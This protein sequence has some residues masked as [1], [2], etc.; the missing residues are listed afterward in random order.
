[1]NLE[2]ICESRCF[3]GLK[4]SDMPTKVGVISSFSI[5]FK[6]NNSRYNRY[7]NSYEINR[8]TKIIVLDS[9]FNIRKSNILQFR[10]NE[11]VFQIALDT[12]INDIK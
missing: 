4:F 6:K 5:F 7:G 8:R 3:V 1:M 12:Y 2:F 9:H 11:V 10:A